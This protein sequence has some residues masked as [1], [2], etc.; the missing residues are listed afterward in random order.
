MDFN[1]KENDEFCLKL[2][3]CTEK[4]DLL[5][6]LGKDDDIE[7]TLGEFSTQS[8][9][10]QFAAELAIAGAKNIWALDIERATEDCR[11]ENSGKICVKL[12]EEDSAREELLSLANE[13]AEE[14]GF[15]PVPNEKQEYLYIALD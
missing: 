6:W 2:I 1:S 4:E 5:E 13:I 14:N 10:E 8:E 9:S 12:P 3:E 7:R 11:F 15:D